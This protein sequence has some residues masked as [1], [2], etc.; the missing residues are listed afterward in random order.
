MKDAPPTVGTALAEGLRFIAYRAINQAAAA[1]TGPG[2]AQSVEHAFVC[3][4]GRGWGC[5]RV[6]GGGGGGGGAEILEL[7]VDLL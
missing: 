4:A 7:E 3:P 5:S 6:G 2:P 1:A